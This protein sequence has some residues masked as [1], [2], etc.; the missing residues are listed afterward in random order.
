MADNK[1]ISLIIVERFLLC[2]IKKIKQFIDSTS[3]AL[4]ASVTLHS[5]QDQL[6]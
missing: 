3:A 1:K 5:H 6:V 4:P 2:Y